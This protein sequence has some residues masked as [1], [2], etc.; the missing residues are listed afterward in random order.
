M[1]MVAV[2]FKKTREF[3]QNDRLQI[4]LKTSLNLLLIVR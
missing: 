2:L 4:F 3:L 1:M